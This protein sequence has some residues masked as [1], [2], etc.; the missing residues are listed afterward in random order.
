MSKTDI[1]IINDIKHEID[2]RDYK[3]IILVGSQIE[4]SSLIKKLEKLEWLKTINLNYHLSKLLHD[5]QKNELSNPIDLIEKLPLESK[6]TIFF[7][8]N[9]ILF[10]SN[11]EWDPLQIFKKLSR[12]YSIVAFWDGYKDNHTLKYA[13]NGHNEF[14]VFPLSDLQDVFILNL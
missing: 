1:E 14:K 2:K 8:Y 13:Q 4:N 11:L 6:S 5:V 10:D 9:N 3:L 12:N 7:N